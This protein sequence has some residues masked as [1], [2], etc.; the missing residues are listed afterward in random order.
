MKILLKQARIHGKLPVRLGQSG[1]E[2]A[3]LDCLLEDGVLVR[4]GAELKVRNDLEI[5]GKQ[6]HLCRGLT[7]LYAHFG[8]PGF[9]YRETLA[10]GTR[11]AL[12]GGFTRVLLQPDTKP[13]L[14]SGGEVASL[15]AAAATL[16]LEVLVA[17]ALTEDLKGMELSDMM[18]LKAHGAAAFSNANAPV[19]EAHAMLRLLQYGSMTGLPLMCVPHDRSLTAGG[20]MHESALSVQMGLKG[21]PAMAETIRLDRDLS[22]LQYLGGSARLHYS[23]ISAA[24]SVARLK[25]AKQ[26]GLSLTCGVAA[27]HL[28]ST[29]SDVLG[30]NTSYKVF[31]PLRDEADRL[32]LMEGVMEGVVEVL[33]SDHQ[34]GDYE[35]KDH[36]FPLAEFGQA[37]IQYAF[38]AAVEAGKSLDSRRRA[39]W[40]R[41]VVAAFTEGP[42][43]VLGLEEHVREDSQE[44][45]SQ[46]WLVFDA[47]A[48]PPALWPSTTSYS[49][50]VQQA[51]RNTSFST[52]IL[53][54]L[55]PSFGN[56]PAHLH[57]RFT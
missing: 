16:P 52:E 18:D 26:N 3:V 40:I 8:T 24:G 51:Y 30:F 49:K 32:A 9:E 57:P 50:G 35:S 47:Q 20:Q 43:R 42:E 48:R 11:A 39:T 29:A 56:Q 36:E 46:G 10:T 2:G 53:A 55:V 38:Q 44:G 41:R 6:I 45:K 12:A 13:V 15:L 25:Q 4:V 54:V 27:H 37:G 17:A 33:C 14:Q 1:A 7:D 21:I 5:S 34:P 19:D 31:P 22:L 23:K 28:F